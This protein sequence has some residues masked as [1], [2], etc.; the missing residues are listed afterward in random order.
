MGIINY[1]IGG[2]KCSLGDNAG[3]MHY[4]PFLQLT[5][6][7]TLEDIAEHMSEHNSKYDEGDIM[8]VLHQF[9]RC[10]CEMASNG[11]KVDL[12][13]L[14][15]LCPSIKVTCEPTAD[16]VTSDNIKGL[17]LH[18]SPGP[19]TA[20]LM[21]NVTFNQVPNRKDMRSLINAENTGQASI[22]LSQPSATGTADGGASGE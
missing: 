13:K 16:A 15:A 19:K 21:D 17:K 22:T 4:R 10:A 9:I 2:E 8:A 11:Y 1:S 5:G 18:W 12:G 3:Q 14:G 20:N 7:V 6:V